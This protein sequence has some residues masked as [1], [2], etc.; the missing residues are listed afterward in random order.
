MASPMIV[1][2]FLLLP[3]VISTPSAVTSN[4]KLV[5]LRIKAALVR[6]EQAVIADVPSERTI[7]PTNLAT[8][9]HP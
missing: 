7:L 9:Q 3:K 4:V 1:V 8:L 2:T 5:L 6:V